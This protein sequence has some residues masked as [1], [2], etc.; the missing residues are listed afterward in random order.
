MIAQTLFQKGSKSMDTFVKAAVD[1]MLSIAGYSDGYTEAVRKSPQQWR[2][3]YTMSRA[4][5]TTFKAW[6][7]TNFNSDVDN[8]TDVELNRQY[9][10]FISKYGITVR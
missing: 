10:L 2:S 7:L 8:R 9:L 4:N 5:L 6:F 1:Q 3:K